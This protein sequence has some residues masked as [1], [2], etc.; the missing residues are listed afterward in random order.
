MTVREFESKV[1]EQDGVRIVVRD[2][3]NAKVKDYNQKYAAQENWRIT[4]FLN[5]RIKPL[6]EDREVVIL[7]GKGNIPNGK[8]LLKKIRQSYNGNGSK[9]S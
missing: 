4:Q 1:W 8:T 7:D 9:K 5:A 3:S 6:V 2:R